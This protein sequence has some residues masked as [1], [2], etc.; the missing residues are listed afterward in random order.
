MT[1]RRRRRLEKDRRHSAPATGLGGR[2]LAAG[3]GITAGA[4]LLMGGVADAANLT[5]DTLGDPG[6][7]GTT[8]LR[9]AMQVINTSPPAD[10][11]IT[12]ASGL[13]GTV[14]LTSQIAI[15]YPVTV[16][17][18]GASQ[19]TID[20]GNAHRLFYLE[21]LSPNTPVTISGLTL[22]H[23]RSSGS[24]TLRNGGAI[25]NLNEA[26]T[27]SDAVLTQNTAA[28]TPGSDGYGGAICSCQDPAGSLTSQDSVV[29]GNT[30]TAYGG[31]VYTDHAPLTIRNTTISGN[32]SA[33]G[34]GG[35]SVYNP[36]ALSRIENSTI[37][38][39]SATGPTSYGGG[40]YKASTTAS[41]TLTGATIVG[42]SAH[43][44]AG[45]DNHQGGATPIGLQNSIVANGVGSADLSGL[46]ASAFS[47]LRTPGSAVVTQTVPGSV[48]TG[49]DPQLGA[50]AANGGFAPTMEPALT[51]PVVDKGAAFGLTTDQ[52]GDTRPVEIPTVPNSSAP[53]ADGSDMGAVELQHP[54]VPTKCK[55]KHK[56]HK[57]RFAESAKK[58]HK[59][60]KCKKK[61]KKKH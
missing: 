24:G 6:P 34:G 52:R 16:Q 50:L 23:G 60:A 61:R 13:S 56:K 8:S 14:H 55:K 44:G 31:G 32:T 59:K 45:I 25:F 10:S 2:R 15:N 9:Q 21:S 43:Q 38:G 42:N 19:I 5:V 36:S 35:V 41:V 49:L 17:G 58:K 54:S 26:L 18:P 51:S 20:G 7:P 40:I 12:F 29:S 39:N 27:V 22:T 3:A 46:F 30:A 47:L 4:T 48:I 37:A 11:H 28:G 33:G 57:K 53:G 1:K